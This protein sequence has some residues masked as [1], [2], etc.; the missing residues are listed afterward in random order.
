MLWELE[1]LEKRRAQIAAEIGTLQGA[2]IPSSKKASLI[3]ELERE[4]TQA[5]VRCQRLVSLI[6]QDQQLSNRLDERLSQQIKP[7]P[8]AEKGLPE[9]IGQLPP[10]Q[11][12]RLKLQARQKE[13]HEKSVTERN[14]EASLLLE[15]EQD[16]GWERD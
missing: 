6:S 1:Q 10:A 12:Q 5:F 9:T 4:D 11:A 14:V 8:E 15:Q 3:A 2:S 7:I 13:W 16:T